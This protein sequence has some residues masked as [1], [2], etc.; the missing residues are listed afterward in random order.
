M[1]KN[2]NLFLKTK[3]RVLEAQNDHLTDGYKAGNGLNLICGLKNRKEK[4]TKELSD[5]KRQDQSKSWKTNPCRLLLIVYS[6]H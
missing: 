6:E 1:N 3:H 5:W 4:T 2:N